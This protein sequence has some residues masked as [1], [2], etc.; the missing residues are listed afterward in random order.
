MEIKSIR[1]YKSKNG[2]IPF[3]IWLKSIS[4]VRSKQ[5]IQANID[6]ISLGHTGNTKYLANGV[7]E[8]KINYSPGY[9]V[10]YAHDGNDIIILL[11]GGD[12]RTQ[13]EDIKKSKKYWS[14]YKS[15]RCK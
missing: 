7:Y 6:K 3:L 14:E 12:K 2:K 1:L 5:I 10:Y 9:R 13:N 8:I 4:D 15:P 11:L